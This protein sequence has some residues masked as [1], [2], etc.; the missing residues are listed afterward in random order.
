[1]YFTD[2][3][4]VQRGDSWNWILKVLRC[5]NE[6]CQWLELKECMGKMNHLS[7]YHLTAIAMVIKCVKIWFIFCICWWQQ[8][9][10]HSLGK[11]VNCTWI[12]YWVLLENGMVN[13]LWSYC[14]WD[15]EV[16]ILQI[17]KYF[18]QTGNDFLL[19]LVENTKNEPFLT[20]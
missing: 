18:A 20:F 6:I 3:D 19:S 9:S 10:S 15:T 5:K 8:K 17:T 13:K 1:M 12:F 7:S 4:I 11:K 2:Q 16:K 14:S